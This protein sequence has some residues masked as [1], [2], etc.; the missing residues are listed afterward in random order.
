MQRREYRG[1]RA[2]EEFIGDRLSVQPFDA[3]TCFARD[4][5]TGRVVPRM[6]ASLV[7]GV[8]SPGRQPTQINCARAESTDI[9]YLWQQFSNDYRL[10]RPSFGLVTESSRNERGRKIV[11]RPHVQRLITLRCQ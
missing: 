2:D 8:D 4:Q 10:G 5:R 1:N 9:A 11:T 3:R 7:V 6:S